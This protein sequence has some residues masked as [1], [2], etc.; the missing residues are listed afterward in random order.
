M[1]KSLILSLAKSKQ[2]PLMPQSFR[3][4]VSQAQGSKLGTS[5]IL[6]LANSNRQPLMPGSF[7][8]SKEVKE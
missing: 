2:Q 3:A 8:G 7:A 5:L 6:N 1:N 4:G